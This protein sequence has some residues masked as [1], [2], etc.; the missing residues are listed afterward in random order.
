MTLYLIKRSLVLKIHANM[1][2]TCVSLDLLYTWKK[3]CT[4]DK[5]AA[6]RGWRLEAKGPRVFI[7][8]SLQ[9][10]CRFTEVKSWLPIKPK[11]I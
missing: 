4:S 6:I 10:P 3:D 7:Q 5:M 11:L 8:T 9:L 1:L 2:N